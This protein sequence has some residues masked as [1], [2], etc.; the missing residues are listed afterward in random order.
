[1]IALHLRIIASQSTKAV[2]RPFHFVIACHHGINKC[3]KHLRKKAIRFESY[4]HW[5]QRYENA[6]LFHV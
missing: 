1:M 6:H 5:S 3:Y 4:V 2:M